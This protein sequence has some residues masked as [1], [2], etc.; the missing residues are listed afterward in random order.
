MDGRKGR[1]RIYLAL[2]PILIALSLVSVSCGRSEPAPW[3]GPTLSQP[4]DQLTVAQLQG[5]EI[6]PL[7]DMSYFAQ[8]IWAGEASHSF[9]GSLT[10]SDAEL[11]FPIERDYYDGENVFPGFTVGFISHDGALIPLE[12]GLIITRHDSESLWDVFVGAGTVWQE[13]LDGAWSRASFPL[14][15]RDRYIGQVRNCV[16][17]F[18]YMPDA[19]SN[20]YVQCSQETA[21][22]AD[23]QLGDM[24]VMLHADYEPQ[25]FADAGEAIESH[26]RSVAARLPVHPLAEIDRDGEITGYFE[27]SLVTNAST[28]IGAVLV[29]A[30]LYVYPASTR[31]GRYPYPAEMRHGVYSVTKSM[32]GALAL[33]HLAER[34]GE[35]VFDELIT[36]HVDALAHHPAWRGVTFAHALRMVTGTEG[37]ERSEHLFEILVSAETA[38]ESIRN[39]ATLGDYPPAPGD[40]FNYASTNYF[41]L[42]YAMQHYAEEKEGPGV[43]YWD[44][45]HDDVLIPIGAEQFTVLHTLERD[46]SPGIPLLAYGATPTLDEAAKIALLFTNEGAH[47]GKQLLHRKR[48]QEALFRSEWPGYPTGDSAITY[49]DSFWSRTVDTPA[50]SVTVTYMEGHGANHVLLLPNEVIVLRFMDENAMDFRPLV[51]SVAEQVPICP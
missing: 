45:V 7:I 31:H 20:V 32:A 13:E 10:F 36:D 33:L 9:S 27:E 44:L 46:A 6:L 14:S 19:L 48:T 42:S 2:A 18:A 1:M 34:Y 24:R 25:Q 30:E 47:E 51:R 3:D 5:D 40:S 41:V 17:T 11:A 39:I 38:E 4:R 23:G 37:S 22:L 29:D 26:V 43:F 21:D 12:R 8:P 15:L 35:G 49:R 28:S 16:A 50:C